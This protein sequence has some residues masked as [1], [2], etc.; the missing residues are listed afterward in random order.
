[1]SRLIAWL[2]GWW[3]AS[4]VLFWAL[5]VLAENDGDTYHDSFLDLVGAAL[6]WMGIGGVVLAPIAG[7]VAASIARRRRACVRFA[8]MGAVSVAAV[9]LVLYALLHAD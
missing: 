9:L 2:T 4:P 1:M 5:A 8:L 6:G 3:L 7:L